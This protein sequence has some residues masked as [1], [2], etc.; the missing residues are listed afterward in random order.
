MPV[1]VQR[2]QPAAGKLES[3]RRADDACPDDDRVMRYSHH[4]NLAQGEPARHPQVAACSSFRTRPGQANW[5]NNGPADGNFMHYASITE[6]LK[7][8]GSEKWFIHIEGARRRSLGQDVIM[9]T[10][11]EPDFSPP[12]AILDV[13]ARR[14]REGRTRYSSGR[15]EP[16]V[17]AAIAGHYAARTG[18][19][20]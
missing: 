3:D 11:G 1:D 10:I 19:Q 12:Q 18:R 17:L 6:R 2:S 16:E 5:L 7:G 14:M 15:G 8:L 4:C 13:A 9:L 20:I